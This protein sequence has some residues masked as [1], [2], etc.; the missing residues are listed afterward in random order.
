ML[1]VGHVHTNHWICYKISIDEHMITMFDLTSM[2][3]DPQEVREALHPLKKHIPFLLTK[4]G[5]AP[6]RE[7]NLQAVLDQFTLVLEYN[8]PQEGNSSDCGIMTLQYIECLLGNRPLSA[9]IPALC[10][11]RQKV[12]CCRLF[13]FRMQVPHTRSLGERKSRQLGVDDECTA[14]C[15]S[16]MKFNLPVVIVTPSVMSGGPLCV[17]A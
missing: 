16:E 11:Y 17:T 15:F 4:A 7:G 12:Y 1:R 13:E 2:N 6:A 10:P 3:S 8:V 14:P 9:I 5:I